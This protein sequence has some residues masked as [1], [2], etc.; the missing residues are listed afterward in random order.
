MVALVA[1]GDGVALRVV[2]VES[3]VDAGTAATRAGA[4]PV[5]GLSHPGKED[6]IIVII[7]VIIVI[8]IVIIVVGVAGGRD[9]A[10]VVTA[11]RGVGFDG[12][13]GV[14]DEGV[15]VGV[16]EVVFDHLGAA[17]GEVDVEDHVSRE[18]A[19]VGAVADDFAS[20][21]DH[22][23]EFGLTG[24]FV[25][26]EVFASFD[27]G[28]ESDKACEGADNADSCDH[29]VHEGAATETSLGPRGGGFGFHRLDPQYMVRVMT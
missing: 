1:A 15:R 9:E 22:A 20:G 12:V 7:I 23:V 19:R 25:E 4:A 10:G 5:A 16:V 13:V 26:V 14:A 8:I 29:D 17:I 11:A 27:F 28:A 3:L 24:G 6:V 18:G 2:A 21:F